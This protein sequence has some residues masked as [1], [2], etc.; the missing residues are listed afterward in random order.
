MVELD[1]RCRH[2]IAAEPSAAAV[3]EAFRFDR[4]QRLAQCHPADAER[5]GDLDLGR[6]LV[7]RRQRMGH[8]Q[9]LEPRTNARMS[10]QISC[11]GQVRAIHKQ[12]IVHRQHAHIWQ[13]RSLDPASAVSGAYPVQQVVHDLVLEA[14]ADG[15]AHPS[16]THPALLPQHPQRLGDGVL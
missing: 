14:V 15:T 11:A 4:A 13:F 1:P 10:G 12:W 3:D 6:Q 5:V 7:A 9:L 2:E 8:D 16:R